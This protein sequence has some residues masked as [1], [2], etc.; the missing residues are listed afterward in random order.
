MATANVFLHGL[1]GFKCSGLPLASV[2][3]ESTIVVL[4]P[5]LALL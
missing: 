5:L 1:M 3:S 4:H 2:V